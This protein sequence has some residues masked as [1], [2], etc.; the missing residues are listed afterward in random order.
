MALGIGW[1]GQQQDSSLVILFCCDL[2]F[3]FFRVWLA[4]QRSCFPG[5]GSAILWA[6]I[7]RVGAAG[8]SGLVW[9]GLVW[10]GRICG[11]SNWTGQGRW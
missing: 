5:I 1:I 11:I 6:G 4:V 7:G 2:A 9:S 8:W 10:S 3:G